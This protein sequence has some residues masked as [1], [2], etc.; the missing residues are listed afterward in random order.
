MTLIVNLSTIHDYSIDATVAAFVHLCNRYSNGC[1]QGM[2]GFFQNWT[3]Y[4]W[5]MAKYKANYA[6][7]IEPY[8]LGEISTETFLDNLSEIFYFMKDI[9]KET[10]SNLLSKAWNASIKL[11]EKTEDRLSQL[12]EKAKTETVY[13]ISNTNELNVHAIV[14]LLKTHNLDTDFVDDIDISINHSQEP[15]EILPNIYLCLSYR[16]GAFKE[17]SA[18]TVSLLD[19]LSDNCPSPRTLVSQYPGDL[20]KGAQLGLEN[21]LSSDDF[22]A[23]TNAYS[24]L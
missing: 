10:R 15:I 24:P 1:L 5:V 6:S 16:Y 11:N 9:D 20:K 7:L 8:K 21:I 12:V 19:H 13:L 18:S 17:Q 2:P 22:Y 23:P 14:D 3:N 4:A